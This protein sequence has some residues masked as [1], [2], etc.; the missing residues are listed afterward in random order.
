MTSVK[1]A[2]R[3][4][5]INQREQEL[6]SKFIISMEDNKTTIT[7]NK[8][9]E[10]V[11]EGDCG[12]EAMRVKE[13]TFDFSF[14]SSSKQD[15]SFASQ[16]HVFQSL[17]L[18]VVRSAYDGYNA[19]VFAYGQTGSGKSYTMM[20]N[21]DD[22]GLIPRICKEL[23]SR[24][25]DGNSSY[26]TEV[27][28]L[29]IYNEKVRDLLQKTNA[30]DKGLHT[31]RVREHP[32]DGPYVQDL[33][34]HYVNN[35]DDIKSLMDY[36]NEKRT[37]AATNM[38][39]VSSRSHAIFT[40]LFTQAKFVK[41]M[42][43]EIHS[44]IHLVDLAGSER[45][46]ATG[47][48]GQRLKEG[49][50]I[51]KSLVTLGNVISVLAEMSEKKVKSIFIPYRNSV[52]TWLLKDSLGGNSRTIMVATISPADV[53]YAETLSTLR[54][55]NRA[56]NIINRPTINEDPNVR[57]IR[58]LRAEIARLRAML[59]GNID[60][61]TTPKVQEKLHENEARVKVLTDEWAGKWKETACILQEQTTLALRKEGLGVVLDSE[62]PHLIGIDDDILS[63]GIMLYH[64]KAGKT[65]IGRGDAKVD[66]D[67]V[68]AGVEVHAE[69]CVIENIDS[70][71]TLYPINNS[72]CTINGVNVIGS[73]KL[74]QGAVIL[75]GKTNMFRFNHPAEAAKMREELKSCNLTFSRTSLL[76][77]S[78][79]DLHRSSD[80]LNALGIGGDF[81]LVHRQEIEMLEEKRQQ[82]ET[83][84][85]KH[86][87]AEKER[88]G[89]QAELEKQLETK[90][91]QLNSLQ[92]EMEKAQDETKKVQLQV[93][94]E[95]AKLKRKSQEI[96]KQFKDYLEEKE[97][98]QME[99][100]KERMK[101]QKETD[102]EIAKKLAERS[103]SC[104]IEVSE[105]LKRLAEQE[106]ILKENLVKTKEM[107]EK[108]IHNLQQKQQEKVRLEQQMEGIEKEKLN[109]ETKLEAMVQQY[110][111]QKAD[112]EYQKQKMRREL[113]GDKKIIEGL[114]FELQE[115]G[116]KFSDFTA[117]H[118]GWIES[119]EESVKKKWYEIENKEI[120][121]IQ[122]Y[123]NS[124]EEL[125]SQHK[126][127]FDDIHGAK[128]QIE[129][130]KQELK[131]HQ[132]L[133]QTHIDKEKNCEEKEKLEW[134]L[135]EMNEA[136][137]QLLLH[138][139][140]HIKGEKSFLKR[141]NEKK[142]MCTKSFNEQKDQIHQEKVALRQSE[143]FRIEKEVYEK[144]LILE[145]REHSVKMQEEI[146]QDMEKNL[147]ISTEKL[148]GDINRLSE[149]Q[150]EMM[151]LSE[152]QDGNLQTS[153]LELK[154]RQDHAEKQTSIELEKIATEKRR[155]LALLED[156]SPVK[157]K[158][159]KGSPSFA[160]EY[161]GEI[162]QV[163]KRKPTM[164]DK[165]GSS[166]DEENS[167]KQ[168]FQEIKQQFKMAESQ[169]EEKIRI[170]EEERDAELERIEYE[171]YKLQELE[172][173]ERINS[174][175]EQEVKV[176]LFEEKV[177]REKQR[178]IEKEQEKKERDDE[179]N[180]LKVMHSREMKQ[181]KAKY[182]RG[183]GSHCS[184]TATKSNPYAT[185]MSPDSLSSLRLE[186]RRM[187]YPSSPDIFTGANQ[188]QSSAIQIYIPTYL[189]RGHGSDTHYEYEVK[190]FVKDESWSVFRRYSRFRQLHTDMKI[191]Y[192]E[193]ASLIF[194]P[195]KL[196]SRSEKVVSE[197]RYQLEFYLRS[198]LEV[199]M[200]I[201]SC[202]INPSNNKFLSKQTLCDFDTFYKKGLF[203]A[204]KH[205]TT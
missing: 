172:N 118:E 180:R 196:F 126:R 125:E 153:I 79:N 200:K 150:S 28:F 142:D 124:M 120:E 17:G 114:T 202:P 115:A 93:R 178:R 88:L 101:K 2:V 121:L 52:L 85:E 67:I 27:S 29:E 40:I 111:Q 94:E 169:L 11:S 32:K 186:H 90:R 139:Y 4:R 97:K 133:K 13:F 48:T 10:M 171:K 198:L 54:Y 105:E 113:E 204:T 119:Q 104:C 156:S 46:D 19:C 166:G 70:V 188:N 173:Q 195:K 185:V 71:V 110:D 170:F 158:L 137:K 112:L 175:V 129:E 201:P 21:Q 37:T 72:L 194:P 57:L 159:N 98:F 42:P 95:Q 6:N 49:A 157:E 116:K 22:H 141:Y 5:P 155:L 81:D 77:Q 74:T 152:E 132:Q 69:H 174:L 20:G 53:N 1:V 31:L 82:I 99:K 86:R 23:F 91:S 30:D 140:D 102:E 146:L 135:E 25:V 163:P 122:E 147:K 117:A 15:S 51:N 41:D 44:K 87:Q 96:E 73:A 33:S 64:L 168:S 100:E 182:E 205:G 66:Q 149:K 103:A 151:K 65:T 59:G 89:K 107:L 190:I 12:R 106:R 161:N 160:I 76:S 183:D 14:W 84:E 203:E 179:I 145:E 189:Y 63:T 177:Q 136:M 191:K 18:D 92:L 123:E 47:A 50:S 165:S 162:H 36:G 26:R 55:A 16:E 144:S 7:N 193:V 8:I 108:E 181:L 35:Y 192:A 56:K 45:A 199:L 187:K 38:N 148:V 130:A 143:K 184:L 128:Q 34:K 43:S 176:R 109:K 75:L 61:I 154:K 164:E 83:M 9:P 3:V 58:E 80:S 127:D 197:R 167:S 134:E 131:K 68:L 24:M 78:M 62:L 138:E 60:N 39:D